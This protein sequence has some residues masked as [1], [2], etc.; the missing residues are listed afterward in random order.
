MVKI[1]VY[2]SP[3]CPHCAGAK[4]LVSQ[5]ASKYGGEVEIEEIDT[6]TKEGMK[7]GMANNIMAVPTV[8]VDGERKFVG[9]PFKE[10]NLL[11]SIEKA[12]GR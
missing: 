5:V 4:K 6:F 8:F 2:Y 12:L 3:V 1:E 9:F 10:E 7:R 11:A